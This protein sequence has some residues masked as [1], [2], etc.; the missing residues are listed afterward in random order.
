LLDRPS[1]RAPPLR[2]EL[3][4]VVF[5]DIHFRG[6]IY[7]MRNLTL[8]RSIAALGTLAVAAWGGQAYA[9][10]P[11]SADPVEP[12]IGGGALGGVLPPP[13]FYFINTLSYNDGSLQDGNGN[14]TSLVHVN[15]TDYVEVPALVWVTPLHLL[16]ASYAVSI[17]QPIVTLATTTNNVTANRTG[18]FN[19]VISPGVLS[20][21]LPLGFFVSAGFSVYLKDGD[22]GDR[23]GG[24]GTQAIHIA[25]NTWTFEPAAAVSWFNGHGFETSL[26]LQYDVQTQDT[27]FVPG[28]K[29]QSGDVLNLNF[30]ALQ[31]LPGAFKKWTV[32][33]TGYYA[34]QTTDD[35]V[36]TAAGT[37]TVGAVPGLNGVGNRFEKLGIGP[38]VG[39]DFGPVFLNAWYERDL[40]AKNATQ[41]DTFFFQLAIPL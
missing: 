31:V 23:G 2:K 29:Y 21:H 22:D 5:R 16:G 33:G 14:P 12:G 37:S 20:W 26:N 28:E 17:A 38:Y 19:T 7:A 40:F 24:A 27:N 6:E 32:G 10:E 11:G 3:A 4:S 8:A 41:G 34:V 35:Q 25:N 30:S 36:T 1:E 39:Y 18:L 13:G 15:V 9:L